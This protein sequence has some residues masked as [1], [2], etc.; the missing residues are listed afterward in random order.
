MN[1]GR[2]RCA[3]SIEDLQVGIRFYAE[4]T[5]S[6]YE[7]VSNERDSKGV[8]IIGY[9]FLNPKTGGLV[10][11]REFKSGLYDLTKPHVKLV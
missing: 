11:G 8:A 2:D 10:D 4:S 5:D 9:R 7:I 1:R 3:E 6:Y